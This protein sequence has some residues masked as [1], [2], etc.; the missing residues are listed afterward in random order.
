[1]SDPALSFFGAVSARKRVFEVIKEIELPCLGV[2]LDDGGNATGTGDAASTGTFGGHAGH[3]TSCER[4]SSA[5]ATFGIYL[6]EIKRTH[7]HV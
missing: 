7:P 2:T 1:V 4:A 5:R 3:P 6:P